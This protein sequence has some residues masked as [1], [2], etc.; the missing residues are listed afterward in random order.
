[1]KLL[2]SFVFHRCSLSVEFFRGPHSVHSRWNPW[3]VWSYIDFFCVFNFSKVQTQYIFDGTLR[4]LVFHRYFRSVEFF[5]RSTLSTFSMEFSRSLVFHRYFLSMEFFR[6]PHLVHF[7]WNSWEVWFFIDI[8]SKCGISLRY[9]LSTFTMKLLR[10]SDFH[11][12]FISVEYF[13]GLYLVHSDKTLEKFDLSSIFSKCE[14]FQRSTFSTFLMKLLRS[15]VFYRYFLSVEFSEVHTQY[16]FDETLEKFG[17]PLIFSK[18]AIFQNSTLDTFSV[19][20]LRSSVSHRNF[21]SVEFF[22][23]LYLVHFDEALEKF[24]LSSIFSKCGIFQRS[25]LSTF[26]MKLWEVWSFINIF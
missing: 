12:D 4:S 14:I 13:K 18:F 22:R 25:T 20:P 6:G 24:D 9:T 17:L 1:M 8:F 15:S 16:I 26:S 21:L 23:D 10:N 7:R 5:Q 19:K 11:R 2:G 3:E